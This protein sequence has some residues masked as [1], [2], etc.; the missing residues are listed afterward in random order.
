[1]LTLVCGRVPPHTRA[2]TRTSAGDALLV[3]LA[4][5]SDAA[6]V[7]AGAHALPVHGVPPEQ[8][9]LGDGKLLHDA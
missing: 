2:L 7:G 8:G 6:L 9:R 5:V 1:M 3:D 4:Q